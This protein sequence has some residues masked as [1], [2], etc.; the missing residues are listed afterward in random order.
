LPKGK[1]KISIK[2]CIYRPTKCE[3]ARKTKAN[4]GFPLIS[5]NERTNYSIVFILGYI[6]IQF[7]KPA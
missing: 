6:A 4:Q 7:W 2:L 5:G 1:R 3:V